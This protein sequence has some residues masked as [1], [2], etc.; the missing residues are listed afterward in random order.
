MNEEH[1][2]CELNGPAPKVGEKIWAVPSHCCTTVNMHDELWYG[3]GGKVEGKW[4]VAA[5]GRVR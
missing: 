3:R 5:R 4:K 2:Y 1:G